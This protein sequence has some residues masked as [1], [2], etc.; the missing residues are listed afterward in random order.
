MRSLNLLCNDFFYMSFSENSWSSRVTRVHRNTGRYWVKQ[1]SSVLICDYNGKNNNKKLLLIN[2]LHKHNPSVWKINKLWFH[3]KRRGRLSS[4]GD[5]FRSCLLTPS[6][7][8]ALDFFSSNPNWLQDFA[9]VYYQSLSVSYRRTLING[10]SFSLLTE[11]DNVVGH[12][13]GPYENQASKS[14][15]HWNKKMK[16]AFFSVIT[17]SMAEFRFQKLFIFLWCRSDSLQKKM[18]KQPPQRFFS[19]FSA[20]SPLKFLWSF[21]HITTSNAHKL[22]M[23]HIAVL[24]L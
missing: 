3:W 10:N 9:E 6:V 19:P 5:L 12:C 24:H 18:A 15:R 1:L 23:S 7:V 16:F 4:F 8:L 14:I 11:L 17:G 21:L 22:W 20:S 2:S 13:A